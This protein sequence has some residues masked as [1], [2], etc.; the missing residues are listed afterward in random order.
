MT[1]NFNACLRHATGEYIQFLCADDL[2]LPGSLRRMSRALADDS[3]VTLAVGGRE[4]INEH[5]DKIAVRKYSGKDITIPGVQAINRCLFG[6]NYIGEPSA[7]MFRRKSGQGGFQESL[8]QLTDLEMWFYLLEPVLMKSL[9][10][11]VCAV[12]R[13]PDQ[14]TQQSI[15]SGA[16]IDENIVLFDEYGNKPYIRKTVLNTAIRKMR[17]ACR[18]WIY[19]NSLTDEKRDGILAAH[20][21]KLFYF[22]MMPAIGRLISTWR[23]IVAATR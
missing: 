15:R 8:S 21:S 11:N 4:L 6:A 14:M 12:R 7:V 3:R 16:L 10:D 23:K 20:S 18:V 13:H 17:I 2:L 5:G 19:R 9:A 1:A 22:L